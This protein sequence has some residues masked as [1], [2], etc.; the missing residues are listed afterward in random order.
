MP[1]IITPLTW[2]AV[3]AITREGFT[4]V[5]GAPN[6]YLKIVNGNRYYFL[7]F[8]EDGKIKSKCLGKFTDLTLA[9]A[10]QLARNLYTPKPKAPFL[11]GKRVKASKYPQS[12]FEMFNVVNETPKKRKSSSLEF[13]KSVTKKSSKSM[14]ERAISFVHILKQ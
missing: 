14:S 9:E 2:R 13:S 11:P 5:G 10:R 4:A 8:R 1:K 3:A 12:Q 7:R 6:L